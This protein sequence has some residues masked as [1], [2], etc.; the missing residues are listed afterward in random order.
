MD[1][2]A[3]TRRPEGPPAGFH[4][5]RTLLF[6]HWEV[7]AEQ[8]AA[9]LPPRLTL[10]TFEGR[11]FIG[12]VPFTMEGIR[13]TRFLPPLP[14]VSA[15]HETNIRT[16]VHLDGKDPGVWFFSLDAA[17]ALAVAGARAGWSL[18]YFVARMTLEHEGDRIHYTSRRVYPPPTPADLDITWHIG[19]D[20]GNALPGT[21]EH[22]L[23]ERY[24]LYAARSSG[25]LFKGQVHHVPYPLRSA[26]IESMSETL[27][28]AAGFRPEQPPMSVLYSPGVDVEVFDLHKV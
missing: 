25:T 14:G 7:P 4:K 28:A 8:L 3:P 21:L 17:N 16:Y 2:L 13:P 19:E 12:L 11:A 6:V 15:F 24:Y 26:R 1:R 22:F 9:V 23:A 18:P 20:L 10:D 5:W 27:V